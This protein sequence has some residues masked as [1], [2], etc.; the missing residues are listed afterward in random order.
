[1]KEADIQPKLRDYI[2]ENKMYGA[3]ELKLNKTKSFAF[4]KVPEHQREALLNVK[5]NGQYHKISDSF[6]YDKKLGRRFPSRKPFD[7]I[8][9]QGNS[10]VVIC[11]YEPRVKKTLYFVDIEIFLQWEEHYLTLG[12]KSIKEE[13]IATISKPVVSLLKKR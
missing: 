10:Y 6:I 4:S 13:E 11:F 7:C 8:N 2:V 5:N 1:M 3:F 12:R 9:I